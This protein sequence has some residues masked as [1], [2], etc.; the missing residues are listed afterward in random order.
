MF[1]AISITVREI[2]QT[3]VGSAKVLARKRQIIKTRGQAVA[4][5]S[6][7]VFGMRRYAS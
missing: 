3:G 7:G 1:A 4:V 5:Q 2:V 6:R